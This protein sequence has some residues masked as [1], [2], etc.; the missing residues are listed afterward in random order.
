MNA[1]RDRKIQNFS[2]YLAV[3][4]KSVDKKCLKLLRDGV[5]GFI[6]LKT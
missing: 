2:G 4:F 6:T 5:Q 3:S 1:R